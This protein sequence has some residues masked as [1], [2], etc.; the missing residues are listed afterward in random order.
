MCYHTNPALE[1]V[2]EGAISLAVFRFEIGELQAEIDQWFQQL[3]PSSKHAAGNEVC[4]EQLN[5]INTCT[6]LKLQ[7]MPTIVLTAT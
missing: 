7:Q 4:V 1:G 3:N 2:S 6:P 5:A